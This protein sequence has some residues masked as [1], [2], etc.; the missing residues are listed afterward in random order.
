[1]HP[2]LITLLDEKLYGAENTLCILD[3]ALIPLW[4]IEKWFDILIWVRSGFD[5]RLKRL[6]SKKTLPEDIFIKRMLLMQ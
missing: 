3:A 4:Q 2:R 1:V 5:I 6:V